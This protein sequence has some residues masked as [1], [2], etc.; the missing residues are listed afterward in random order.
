MARYGKFVMGKLKEADRESV[1][2]VVGFTLSGAA[3]WYTVEIQKSLE[4]RI[5]ELEENREF[6]EKYYGVDAFKLSQL[7]LA[8]KEKEEMVAFLKEHSA[9]DPHF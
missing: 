9:A 5:N 8:R 1:I 4:R 6:A 2:R 3:L 7:K